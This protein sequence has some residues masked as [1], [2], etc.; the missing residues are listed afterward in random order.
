R[1]RTLIACPALAAFPTA[2]MA[3]ETTPID[4]GAMP[5]KEV[6]GVADLTP[7]AIS[8]SGE[9]AVVLL[10]LEAGEVVPP[11][12]AKS[13]LRL[14]TVISGAT[15][16]GDGGEVVEGRE[17]VYP[18]GSLLTVPAKLDHWLA[19]RSGPARIRVIVLDDEIVVPG[20]R[21]QMK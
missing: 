4:I 2:A 1:M 8:A 13:G 7:L 12:A 17:T 21:S 18:P 3:A 10:D 15:S 16:W 14:L 20:V 6:Y 11:H 5:S 9:P 19:A